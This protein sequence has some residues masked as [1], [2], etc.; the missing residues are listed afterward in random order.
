MLLLC[1]LQ[2]RLPAAFHRDARSAAGP[3]PPSAAA[4]GGGQ[5]RRGTLFRAPWRRNTARGGKA[6]PEYSTGVTAAPLRLHG[7]GREP[8]ISTAP[9]SACSSPL[10]RPPPSCAGL[11]LRVTRTGRAGRGQEVSAPEG[12]AGPGRR[13][14]TVFG[15]LVFSVSK[16]KNNINQT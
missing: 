4:R 5:P 10:G 12:V 7:W 1:G 3:G 16:R 9:A 8:G 14:K 6:L 13:R 2:P 15:G 11:R